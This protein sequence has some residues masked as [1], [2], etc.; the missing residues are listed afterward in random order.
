MSLVGIRPRLEE[1]KM[2]LGQRKETNPISA[3]RDTLK[4]ILRIISS[5]RLR[6]PLLTSMIAK[7]IWQMKER[8]DMETKGIMVQKPTDMMH[9]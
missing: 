2:A 6:L 3:T 7:W 1:A 9:Q 5:G 4:S 8:S